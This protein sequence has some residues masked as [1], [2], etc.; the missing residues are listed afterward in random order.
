MECNRIKSL[1]ELNQ[2]YRKVKETQVKTEHILDKE[3]KQKELLIMPNLEN[4][5]KNLNSKYHLQSLTRFGDGYRGTKQGGG[6]VR[7]TTSFTTKRK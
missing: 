5:T 2:I 4:N 7:W 1:I 6:F 3:T